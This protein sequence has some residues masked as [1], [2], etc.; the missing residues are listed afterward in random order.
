[1]FSKNRDRL[2]NGEIAEKFFVQ[3]LS[4]ARDKDLLSDEHFSVDGTLIEAWASQKSFQKKDRSRTSPPDDPGNP[5]IDFH[6]EERRNETHEST[7]DPEARLARKSG[8]HESK[9][10]YCGNV[11]I[12]NR[13]GLV[14]DTKLVLCSGKAE[15]EAA[16]QMAGRIDGAQRVTVGADKGY[17]TQ[18]FVREMRER[19][20]TPHVSQNVNRNGGSAIDGRTT[21]HA[22]YQVSQ[23][24]RK[25]IEEVFGWLKTVGMLRKTRHR[26]VFKVG[27]VFTFAAA[28][29]NLV[30]MRNLAAVPSA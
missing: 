15:R 14:V 2:L 17:D 29:Y 11:L 22:G 1:M 7:T 20:V 27:W 21:R 16:L 25:R 5:S 24:K 28:A 18:E 4:Q 3:V 8:G 19:N 26:G 12:E 30:R 13:N 10:A 9:L 6:G 23:R